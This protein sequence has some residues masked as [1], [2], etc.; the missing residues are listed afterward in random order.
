MS[1]P[2]LRVEHPADDI[3]RVVLARAEA[4]NAQDPQM[5]YELNEAFCERSR[6]PAV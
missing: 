6:N 3:L 4:R 1:M 2:R 5:L